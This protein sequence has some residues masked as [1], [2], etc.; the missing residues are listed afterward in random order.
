MDKISMINVP[1]G[2]PL[3]WIHAVAVIVTVAFVS[4]LLYQAFV[5][6]REDRQSWLGH[7]VESAAR[8]P[9]ADEDDLAERRGTPKGPTRPR[10]RRRSPRA[11]ASLAAARSPFAAWTPCF[12]A[13]SRDT[14]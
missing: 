12:A 3:L 11:A 1:A 13:D 4:I 8:A 9:L 10:T 5:D 2:S 6:Y 14:C 7:S